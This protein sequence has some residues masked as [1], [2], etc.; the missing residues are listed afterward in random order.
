MPS[1]RHH[2]GE[3]S[4]R[5]AVTGAFRPA[6]RTLLSAVRRQPLAGGL[7]PQPPGDVETKH[8]GASRRTHG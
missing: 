7:A 8:A 5:S 1:R 4:I 2:D 3:D 6:C